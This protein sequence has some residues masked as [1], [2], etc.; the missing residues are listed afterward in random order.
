MRRIRKSSKPIAVFLLLEFVLEIVNPGVAF[1]LTGGPN[2]PEFAVFQPVS[3]TDMV[4]LFSGDFS[5]NIPVVNIPGPDG[6][7]YAMS[8]SYQS[9]IS[10]EEEASWVGYGWNLNP[11]AINRNDRG[12]PDDFKEGD[13]EQY[14]KVRPNWSVSAKEE[15]TL[16][17]KSKDAEGGRLTSG[18][19]LTGN[20]SDGAGLNLSASFS[21][22]R[23]IRFNNYK[24]YSKSTG[25]GLGLSGMASLNYN[26]G[27]DGSSFGFSV[28]PLGVMN[29]IQKIRLSKLSGNPLFNHNEEWWSGKAS[30]AS[31]GAKIDKIQKSMTSMNRYG[32]FAGSF[33]TQSFANYFTPFSVSSYRGFG[34][35]FSFSGQ[36]GISNIGIQNGETGNYNVQYNE[37]VVPMKAY[38]YIH[39]PSL[40][41]IKDDAHYHSYLNGENDNGK[42]SAAWYNDVLMDYTVE[43]GD[44]INPRDRYLGIP[45]S[46]PDMFSVTGE[47]VSG[48]FRFYQNKL[49]TFYPNL[50]KSHQNI[51]HLGLEVEFSGIGVVF[52]LD[53]GLVGEQ[54]T[55]LG[56]WGD[57]GE[58]EDLLKLCDLTDIQL[59]QLQSAENYESQ[60]NVFENYYSQIYSTDNQQQKNA[61]ARV[62]SWKVAYDRE[63][64]RTGQD[65]VVLTSKKV[66]NEVTEAN[67]KLNEYVFNRV[68]LSR[69]N[70]CDIGFEQGGKG[71]FRFSND[72][73]G[74]LTYTEDREEVAASLSGGPF[75]PG[76]R[77]QGY[78]LDKL[79]LASLS[80]RDMERAGKIDFKTYADK[81]NPY[82]KD[83]QVRDFINSLVDV[84]E[85]SITEFA[86]QSQDGGES[87][88]GLPVYI[89]NKEEYSFAVNHALDYI[90]DNLEMVYKQDIKMGDHAVEN[91]NI[92]GNR[93]KTPFSKIHL[94]TQKTNV[95][96][97]DVGVD[98]VPDGLDDKDF[99]GWTKFSYRKWKDQNENEWYRYRSPYNGFVYDK[100]ELSDI[101]DDAAGVSSGEKQVYYMKSVET[102]THIAYFVT[103]KTTF[104]ELK[105]ES[106]ALQ[107]LDGNELQKIKSLLTG[108]GERMDAMGAGKIPDSGIDPRANARPNTEVEHSNQQLEYLQRIV[109]FSKDRPGK[110]LQTVNF[111]YDYQLQPGVPNSK[112]NTGKLTLKKLWID[113]EGVVRSRIAPYVFHYEYPKKIHAPNRA[114]TSNFYPE[115]I[116]GDDAP[117]K[118]VGDFL[119][120]YE[121]SNLAVENPD[122]TTYELDAWGYYQA[123][124]DQRHRD[125]KPWV[126]QGENESE[127]QFFDPAAWHLKR[128]K[129]PS[130]G[131][132]HIQYEQKD[133]SYVQNQKAMAMVSIEKKAGTDNE[134]YLSLEDIDYQDPIAYRDSLE[135]Y[136]I[137]FEGEES[138]SP[139][140]YV[141]FK[142]LYD[143][144]GGTAGIDDCHSQYITGYTPIAEVKLEGDRVCVVL[145]DNENWQKDVKL[146]SQNGSTIPDE[147]C[148]DFAVTNRDGMLDGSN[149]EPDFDEF[150]RVENAQAD[151]VA[152]NNQHTVFELFSSSEEGRA[153]KKEVNDSQRK[154][155]EEV[156]KHMNDGIPDRD[157]VCTSINETLSYLRLPLFKSK[158]GGG[159]RVKRLLMYDNGL[160][161]GDEV[162]Y[163][164]EYHYV[165]S[166]GSSSGVATNEPAAAREEN[167][168]VGLLDRGNQGFWSRAISGRDKKQ[169]EGPLGETILPVP[170]IGYGRVVVHNIHTGRTGTGF[171]E[172]AFHTCK[173]YPFIETH[174][175]FNNTDDNKN[176]DWLTLPLGIVNLNVRKTW[177]TQGYQFIKNNMHGQPISVQTYQ[178]NYFPNK[179]IEG[180]IQENDINN[181]RL[182]A[183]T[184]YEYYEP[185]G[186]IGILSYDSNTNEFVK[187]TTL[188]GMEEDITLE[189]RQVQDEHVDLNLELDVGIYWTPYAVEVGLLGSFSFDINQLSTHVTSKIVNYPVIL[190]KTTSLVD[191]VQ[192][193]SENLLFDRYTGSPV[194][195]V[196]YDGYDGLNMSEKGVHEGAIYSYNLPAHWFYDE[197]GQ[198]ARSD[199]N[200]NQLTASAGSI[201]AYGEAGNF[202]K[203]L[204]DI[205]EGRKALTGSLGGVLSASSTTFANDWFIDSNTDQDAIKKEYGMESLSQAELDQLN[206]V[207]RGKA[208]Y[209]YYAAI[210][211]ANELKNPSVTDDQD[212]T[213]YNSGMIRNFRFFDWSSEEL[214]DENNRAQT[215]G[216]WLMTNQITKYSPHGN[217]LEESDVLGIASAARYG[218]RGKILP[219]VVAK[220][221]EYESIFFKDFEYGATVADN[222]AAHSGFFSWN[223]RSQ[224]AYKVIDVADGLVLNQHLIDEGGVMKLW[225]KRVNSNG[226]ITS[227]ESPALTA[228]FNDFLEVKMQKVAS[229]GEWTQYQAHI[230]KWNGIPKGQALTMKVNYQF[231]GNEV[232]Y[233]DDVRFQPYDAE[234]M[235][236]VYD[237]FSL[238]PVAEFGDQHFG[239][240]YQYN[241]EAQLVRKSIETERGMRTLQENQYNVPRELRPVQ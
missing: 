115:D 189:N 68:K 30:D 93:T 236:Y 168:L 162:L 213:V 140:D 131:E 50:S 61:L 132:I 152:S 202:F 31:N 216:N 136:F 190:K 42:S 222:T 104:D 159:V 206:K 20:D 211:Q 54:Y 163:G 41:E 160:Q 141:Y 138:V 179:E 81:D 111:Q 238:K 43:K 69:G 109:L 142:F 197:M 143:I 174:T 23:S 12:Y 149:C 129:L 77:G 90:D 63:T 119:E 226:K 60:L 151:L 28:N 82:E 85:E 16:E 203:S 184:K 182:T 124:G 153:E 176:K 161:S 209:T 210:K 7:G 147:V 52:G 19:K 195:T 29:T 58:G 133:Y 45:F 194:V 204:K 11:G 178:G 219:T 70:I 180:E 76:L 113:S 40:D 55:E 47:G 67:F 106:T 59:L 44:G 185:G 89:R 114:G 87:V 150:D 198:S 201:V 84:P 105:L 135:K 158:R 130:G 98:G 183:S 9:G 94:L 21:V 24:G 223:L 170:S 36:V 234:V 146:S 13:I 96:Y 177:L 229:T 92:T 117:Y 75:V 62:G 227:N 125:L 73:G 116:A 241:N 79:G 25:F 38:G 51:N 122:Y 66:T 86:I 139:K 4:S 120:K 72:M 145:G 240:F 39:S 1:A 187:E 165:N 221:A 228:V 26:T 172:H 148:Y 112:D 175:E 57:S 191:N 5:Y 155:V 199:N 49:G 166:D 157:D 48:G 186:E 33:G 8:L 14:A 74:A 156:F 164:S 56:T 217:P 2:S 78:N 167:P 6:G 46:T 80:D 127:G 64:T 169:F 154:A 91:P 97:V 95:N 35:N 192:T 205:P 233:I 230:R 32:N 193:I 100:N 71:F 99:G 22:S 218:Y 17:V 144:Y 53:L 232:V 215:V 137:R 207:Y 134:Y 110:P 224:P 3:T 239:V 118:E 208:T 18:V 235:C 101:R 126:Y 212:G 225:L 107:A 171:Q 237:K 10:P 200:T 196:T 102:K 27:S 103:N 173:D 128:V 181:K 65:H 121:M 108:S 214:Y 34:T 231:E 123:N 220:N 15:L 37:S 83:Q 88:Y 188:P